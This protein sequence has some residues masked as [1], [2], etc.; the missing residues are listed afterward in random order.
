MSGGVV[1]PAR[2][3]QTGS[4][5]Q[6][7]GSPLIVYGAPRSGTSYLNAILN[8]HP[9]VFV[10]HETRLF[11][12]AHESLKVATQQ[13]RL[14]LSERQRFVQHLRGSYPKLIRDFYLTLRPDVRCWGDKNPH[15]A[16]PE[17]RGCLETIDELFPESRFIHIVRDGRDVATSL[18]RRGWA[19]F[20]QAHRIWLNHTEIG[21]S[22]GRSRPV[23]RYLE[24]RYEDLVADDVRGARE[25]F[26]FLALD[27]HPAVERFCLAQRGARSPIQSPTRDLGTGASASEW[28]EL[29][30][31]DQ[32]VHSLELL[33]ERLVLYG[34]ESGESLTTTKNRLEK[35]VEIAG[36]DPI[37]E[38]VRAVVP[39]NAT[40]LVASGGDDRLLLAMNGCRAW[41][42]PQTERDNNT[43][44]GRDPANSEEAI[45]HVE[46]LR[47]RGAGF[48]VLPQAAGWWLGEYKGFRNYLETQHEQLW[49]GDNCTIYKLS[50]LKPKRA[51]A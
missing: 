45:G 25:I 32:Q 43:P 7:M 16:S 20:G 21:S 19:G 49:S 44:T 12:W 47:A 1:D 33:G 35:E 40:V 18:I 36:S 30:A 51:R 41:H 23:G 15:Y 50:D 8:Q 34:Y 46:R 3:R 2:R 29:L 27:F 48:L 9:S 14:L 22:F 38:A 31:P 42:I 6:A 26:D 11:V 37:R 17:N 24:I 5:V 28:A 39:A 4:D 13:D 10:T